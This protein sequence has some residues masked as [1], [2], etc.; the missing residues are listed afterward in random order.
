M[1]EVIGLQ[2]AIRREGKG[3]LVYLN[4]Q[5]KVIGESWKNSP[6]SDPGFWRTLYK[7]VKGQIEKYAPEVKDLNKQKQDLIVVS[8]II[9]RGFKASGASYDIGK[10]QQLLNTTGGAGLAGGAI[11]G[12]AAACTFVS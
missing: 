2:D 6:Q 5:K 7:D 1:N 8:P 11:L 3:S 10:V 4:Q 12:A 9:E